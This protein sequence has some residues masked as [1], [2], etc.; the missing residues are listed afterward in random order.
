MHILTYKLVSLIALRGGESKMDNKELNRTISRLFRDVAAKEKKKAVSSGDYA[1][2]FVA[3]IVEGV[4][5]DA[6]SAIE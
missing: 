4:A 3:A 1:T 6:E 5:R 2:A